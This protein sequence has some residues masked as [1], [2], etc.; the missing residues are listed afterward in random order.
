MEEH[1]FQGILTRSKAA[2]PKEGLL[3]PP[4]L[5]GQS[6]AS[7]AVSG[8]DLQQVQTPRVPSSSSF[9]VGR[10]SP[11]SNPPGLDAKNQNTGA[12]ANK[13]LCSNT[14]DGRP[15]ITES[16][17][18]CPVVRD[19]VTCC[20]VCRVLYQQSPGNSNFVCPVCT[21]QKAE[22]QAF[23]AAISEFRSSN[24]KLSDR[25]T[26]FEKT[27]AVLHAEFISLKNVV[28]SSKPGGVGGK[29]MKSSQAKDSE[30]VTNLDE[31]MDT[32][33]VPES[34]ANLDIT[35][36]QLGETHGKLEEIIE[37]SAA[38]AN[39][40]ESLC[41]RAERYLIELDTKVNTKQV[42]DNIPISEPAA[43]GNT[44]LPKDPQAKTAILIGDSN[45]ARLSGTA[46][47][48]LNR[49][50]RFAIRGA[51]GHTEF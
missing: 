40:L 6:V 38:K 7:S 23:E 18:T 33:L 3:A 15:A 20:S 36:K 37:R 10:D 49:D 19:L 45:V 35:K 13:L 21:Q 12:S 2:Q 29:E 51:T 1:S 25:L 17:L 4:R 41:D 44:E 27:L 43:V 8:V 28:L 31:Q 9:S 47:N 42:I 34:V 14:T 16:A 39:H 32:D 50:G 5:S 22:V 26:E 30:A 48:M 11:I 46:F 24:K